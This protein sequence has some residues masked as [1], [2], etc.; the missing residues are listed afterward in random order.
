MSKTEKRIVNLK[1]LNFVLA[2][3]FLTGCTGVSTLGERRAREQARG[4][5]AAFR[6]QGQRAPLPELRPESGL[7]EYLR[8]AMLN[9]P[10]VAAAYYDWLSAIE[11]ITQERS[12]PDPKLTFEMYLQDIVTS[13]MPGLMMDFPGPGKLAARAQV[14]TAESEGKY[15][16]FESSV[17]QA[18]FALKKSFYQLYFLDQKIRVNRQTLELL[19]E[20]EN[21]ARAQNAVGKVTLQDVLRAQIEQDRLK[22]EVANLEDSR[23]SFLAQFKAALGLQ[24]G[25]PTPPVPQRLESTPLDLTSEKLFETALE[26]N[27][28]LKAMAAEVQRAEASL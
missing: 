3:W 7:G 11:R 8:Y 4:V 12:L 25:Q 18:A 9:R 27:P 6:P 20:L 5:A 26:R 24:P 19:A 28:R 2:G 14:A 1:L 22:T 13:V 15:F 10:Q 16:A 17:L 23:A 21:L